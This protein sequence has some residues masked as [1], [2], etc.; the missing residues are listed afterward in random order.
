MDNVPCP[1]SIEDKDK[2]VRNTLNLNY[3]P[4]RY[5]G[6]KRGT[7]VFIETPP[8]GFLCCSSF[9]FSRMPRVIHFRWSPK[10]GFFPSVR[11]DAFE[12]FSVWYW[13]C[14]LQL[15][16]RTIANKGI[17]IFIFGYPL[18]FRLD[19]GNYI[20]IFVRFFHLI[21]LTGDALYLVWI[22]LHVLD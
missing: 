7:G 14:V 11:W 10:E 20:N 18:F 8:W 3:Y 13:R 9:I 22:I 17:H 21:F 5:S 4:D 1:S 2:P 16:N 6:G 12:A 19:L 15:Q